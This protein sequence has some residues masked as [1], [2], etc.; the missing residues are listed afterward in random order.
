V[1]KGIREEA[2]APAVELRK[3]GHSEMGR[4]RALR[5]AAPRTI[6]R[7]VECESRAAKEMQK[8]QRRR[9]EKEGR[10]KKAGKTK[11]RKR[12]GT[13]EGRTEEEKL[14]EQDSRET[15]GGGPQNRR[16]ERKVAHAVPRAEGG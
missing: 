16:L 2:A 12:R 7:K 14:Q 4:T 9:K 11:I 3:R 15:E 5:H 6:R 10:Y 13:E 8:P 1:I